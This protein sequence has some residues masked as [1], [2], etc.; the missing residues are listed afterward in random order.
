MRAVFMM[1][2]EKGKTPNADIFGALVCDPG[3]VI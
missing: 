2:V 3:W 1:M